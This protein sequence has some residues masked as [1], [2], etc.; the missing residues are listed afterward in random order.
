MPQININLGLPCYPVE[1]QVRDRIG[2]LQ[3]VERV[4]NFKSLGIDKYLNVFFPGEMVKDPKKWQ[5][6]LQKTRDV[7]SGVGYEGFLPPV[8]EC[9]GS[10]KEFDPRLDYSHPESED[11]LKRLIEAVNLFGSSLLNVHLSTTRMAKDWKNEW[12]TPEYKKETMVSALERISRLRQQEGYE[13]IITLETMPLPKMGDVFLHPEE[14]AYD[15]LLTTVRALVTFNPPEGIEL[16]LDTSHTG[17]AI[18]KI[19]CLR[20][21]YKTLTKEI[22]EDEGIKGLDPNIPFQPSLIDTIRNSPLLHKVGLVHFSDYTGPWEPNSQLFHEGV[23][24][25][26]GNFGFLLIDLL[27]EINSFAIKDQRRIPVT[28]EVSIAD[29]NNAV[30][31]EHGL[32]LLMEF[33][34]Y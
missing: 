34:T 27:R 13:G 15:I 6:T 18:Q 12:D 4:Y 24:P 10:F 11:A 28:L 25:L 14:M 16:C 22:L 7:L 33:L 21:K 9:N 20:R 30:E 8:I 19:N 26:E 29:Y 17:L 2:I 31:M 1:A 23:Q 3:R 32:E 5:E